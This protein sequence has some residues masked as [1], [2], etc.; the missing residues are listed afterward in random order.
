MQVGE[1]TPAQLQ[2]QM[3]YYDHEWV[4]LEPHEGRWQ[5]GV[6][7]HM[8]RTLKRRYYLVEKAKNAHVIG[9]GIPFSTHIILYII[10]RQSGCMRSDL[11]TN[12]IGVQAS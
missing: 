5:D 11:A 6:P 1:D 2:L 8:T 4:M 9:Q 10:V 3:T 12:F 7:L